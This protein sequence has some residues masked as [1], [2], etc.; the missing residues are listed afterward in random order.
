M[1]IYVY[2]LPYTPIFLNISK[3]FPRHVLVQLNSEVSLTYNRHTLD[4]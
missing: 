1:G 3:S 4:I 2:S